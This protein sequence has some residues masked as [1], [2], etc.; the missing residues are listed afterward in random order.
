MN[1]LLPYWLY[2]DFVTKL[3]LLCTDLERQLQTLNNILTL[4]RICDFDKCNAK[5]RSIV[6]L[7]LIVL[8]LHS[9]LFLATEIFNW[10]IML[11][12]PL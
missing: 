7:R 1:V 8:L 5:C 3:T 11:T 2:R 10:L 9:K 4:H 6:T 12:T